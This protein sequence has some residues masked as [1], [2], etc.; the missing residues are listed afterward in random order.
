MPE[1]LTIVFSG[2]MVFHHNNANNAMEIG[3]LRQE[4]HV[5]RILTITN[6]VLADVFDLRTRPEL[7]DPNNR[8]WRLEVTAP[9][10]SGISVYT[11]GSTFDRKTHNDDRDF[12]WGMDFEG[13]DFYD[14]DLSTVMLTNRLTPVLQIPSGEFYTRLKS[15]PLNR[16]ED[17]G[18]LKPF[19]AIAGVTGCDISIRGGS[20]T[21]KD[22]ADSDIFR[23]KID[24]APVPPNTIFEI[25]N[26]PPDVLLDQNSTHGHVAHDD[27]HSDHFQF[28]Y[29]LFEPQ[30]TPRPKF[31]FES[32]LDTA[33]GPDPRLCGKAQVGLRTDPL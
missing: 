20:V 29:N 33:P 32:A 14:K 10:A 17:G 22:Q 25:A 23:F 16:R 31:G 12:R 9:A 21:L 7:A 15:E 11:N 6:G 19:G 1:T 2:L 18:A 30:N 24:G 5:P 8:S 27:L 13:P 26:T 3:I 28:Y 4:S